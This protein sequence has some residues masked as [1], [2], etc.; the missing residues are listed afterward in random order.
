MTIQWERCTFQRV[1]DMGAKKRIIIIGA[2]ASGLMAA[3]S[4]AKAGASV[5]V[6]DSNPSA[7]RKINAT[8]NGR[9]NFTNA[10][11]DSLSHYYA[12]DK[13]FVGGVLSRF[14]VCDILS[15]F[16]SI[17]IE[18][19]LEDEGK[20]FPLSGQA[21]AVSEL[22]YKHLC[23]LGVEF[24]FNTKVTSVKPSA[25]GVN[26]TAGDDVLS[27]DGVIIAGGGMA[28]PETGSD[29]FC[30]TLAKQL[31]HNVTPTYPVIVQMKTKGGFYKSLSG[32][33]IKANVTLECDHKQIRSEMGDL[34][35]FDYGISGPPVFHVSVDAAEYIAKG[36]SVCC[37]IDLLP[38]YDLSLLKEKLLARVNSFEGTAEDLFVGMLHKKLTRLVLDS[39]KVPQ[40]VQINSLNSVQINAIANAIKSNRVEIIGT[41]GWENAQATMGGVALDGVDKKTLASKKD[42]RIAF[43]GEVLDVVGDCGGYNLTWAWS[44]GFVAGKGMVESL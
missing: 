7:G 20:Y 17:G 4:A 41:K 11:A 29:G 2:G 32:L 28:S 15:L 8:G 13:D 37:V 30:Y 36:K 21:S 3:Y 1:F 35:F 23:S 38:D 6:I 10:D 16:E 12:T 40:T 18:P 34:L 27:C 43:C 9:C 33:R 44:S 19:H 42:K 31:G 5:L 22:L 26:V 39:A 14:S 24:V 25:K